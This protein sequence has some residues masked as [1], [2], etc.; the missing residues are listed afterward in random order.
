VKLTARIAL[1]IFCLFLCAC[2]GRRN[3]RQP[4]TA[5][6]EISGPFNELAAAAAV[7]RDA[8]RDYRGMAA[9][10]KMPRW[11]EAYLDGG[12]AAVE[13]LD[14]YSGQYV[15]VSE[16]WGAASGPLEQWLQRFD[17]DRGF[18]RVA[19]VR[20][21][22]RFIRDLTGSADAVY[23]KNYENAI[24][25]A[26]DAAYTG[27][28]KEADFWIREESVRG[29]GAPVLQYRYFIL[30]RVPRGLFE[31]QT[32]AFLDRITSANA[33]KDQNLAF[34]YVKEHFFEGY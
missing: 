12:A 22:F 24:K 20:L 23:G 4:L 34:D 2:A 11:F 14:E 1:L 6:E 9:G 26:Y 25:A 13:S 17:I 8:I 19:A 29:D 3:R 7:Q 27:Y 28:R 33:A 21:R 32:R 30:I 18:P 5:P 15:F 16:N 31:Q 10:A